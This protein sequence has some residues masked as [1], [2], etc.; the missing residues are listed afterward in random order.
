MTGTLRWPRLIIACKDGKIF[1]WA[2]S[3]VAPKKTSASEWGTFILSSSFC[4]F[5]QMPAKLITHRREQLV[6][7]IRLAAG[8]EALIERRTQHVSRHCFVD[9]SFDCPA[10]LAGV[11]NSAFELLQSRI[12]NQGCRRQ[13]E[14][15]RGNHAAAPPHFR[16]V[17]KIEIVLVMFRVAQRCR[18]GIDLPLLLADV[19]GSQD[20]EPLSVGGHDAV[21][22]PVMNHLDEVA[23]AIGAAM[24]VTLFGGAV[25]LLAARGA[26]YLVAYAGSQPGED[27]IEMLDHCILTTNHHAVTTLQ[28]P[29]PTTCAHIDVMNSFGRKLLGAPDV[30]YVIGI[31][32]VDENVIALEMGQEIG[33]GLIHDRGRDHQPNRPR[34]G[35]FFNKIAEGRRADCL[36]LDQL[37]DCFLRPVEDHTLMASG[38][39]PPHHVR[40]HSTKTNHSNLHE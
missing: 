14:Q 13:I 7:K 20:T 23:G 31:A 40:S 19:G 24:Q 27:W 5:F 11:R 30:I 36:F 10:P 6:G 25:G 9:G 17:R 22:D 32:A 15:P 29:D 4:G 37:L 8:A 38:E 28:A 26:R 16:D 2:R 1:L 3:P 18:L 33:D 34:L 21:L 39:K 35:Q 12:L